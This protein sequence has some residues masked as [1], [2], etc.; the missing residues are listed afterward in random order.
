MIR[1]VNESACELFGRPRRMVMGKPLAT[2]VAAEDRSV[3]DRQLDRIRHSAPGGHLTV[4]LTVNDGDPVPTSLR[5][6]L[7]RTERPDGATI[8]WLLRDRRHDLVTKALRTSE[9][10]LRSL[11]T[12]AQV[13]MVLC[14]TAR[15]VLF[16]NQYADRVLDRDGDDATLDGWMSRVHPDDRP[17]VDALIR[18]TTKAGAPGSLRH[19]VVHRDGTVLWLDHSV[20]PYRE[21]DDVTGFVST[22]VDVTAET[23]AMTDLVDSRDFTEALLDTAGALVVVIDPD[24][25]V[26]RFNKACEAVTGFRA[27]DVVGRPLLD[28]L[29]PAD[30]RAEAAKRLADMQDPDTL[31]HTGSFE[32]DWSTADGRRRRISWT[33]TSLADE[34]GRLTATIG[35]GI[36]VTEKRVL[37]SRLA[38][39][40]RLQAIGRLTAG[41]A[42]DFSN[43][44]TTLRLRA[45]RMGSRD[46]DEATRADL[47]AGVATIDRTQQLIAD[48]LSFSRRAPSEAMRMDVATEILR[49]AT[50]L[51]ELFPDDISIDLELSD[52]TQTVV[53]DPA[54]FEQ[55]LTNLAINASDA[56]SDGGTLTI[57]TTVDSIH[58]DQ[59]TD[60][61]V[62]THL[63]AG[64]YVVMAVSDT[65][66]GID[67]DHVEHVFDPYFTTKPAGRGT[68]LGLATTYGTIVQSGGAILVDS[69]PGDGTTFRIWLPR[70]GRPAGDAA[71]D[72]DS[73]G[74]AKTVL[75]VDDDDDLRQVLVDE[76]TSLGHRTLEAGDAATAL[77]HLDEPI[78][79]LV[80]DVQLP[81]LSGHEVTARMLP[82]HPD[83]SVVYISGAPSEELRD[84]LPSDADVLSKPFTTDELL[85]AIDRAV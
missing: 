53:I 67:P 32:S 24:R 54:R 84:V 78:D 21:Q 36:D 19:R 13:G 62:P 72:D 31:G 16:A 59:H 80:C 39:A 28:H 79:L 37:E 2:F 77:G 23:S 5:A 63:P 30:R 55:A 34:A 69:R 14:D 6:T 3:F 85:E 81:D 70:E 45:D 8:T 17:A 57:S 65:G 15:N 52:E 76:L 4:D 27:A 25:R 35:V 66:T 50:I 58:A 40:D 46:L 68:G 10:R 22:L 7:V 43:T 11:F 12:T 18:R 83:M 75:V 47:V 1:E 73:S 64:D 60:A 51:S 29:I 71:G 56:M 82:R 44:L 61:R 41:V 42:H 20:V 33:Y 26:L 38:Q 74:R 9:G 48:L 49:V